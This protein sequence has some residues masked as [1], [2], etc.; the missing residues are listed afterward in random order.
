MARGIL[1]TSTAPIAPGVSDAEIRD[2]WEAAY[3]D[4]TFVHLLPAGDVPAHG[5]RGRVRTPR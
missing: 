3:A 2:A 5:R 1:A 4:E